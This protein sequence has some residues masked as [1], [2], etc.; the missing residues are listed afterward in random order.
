MASMAAITEYSETQQEQVNVLES[1][2]G[3]NFHR[4]QGTKSAWQ[5]R[6]L[7]HRSNLKHTLTL[8]FCSEAS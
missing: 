5:V 8:V 7:E 1:I 3:E 6:R 4:V 2:Y